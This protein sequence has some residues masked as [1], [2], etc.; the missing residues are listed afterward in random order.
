M[1]T[2]AGS[3]EQDVI[4]AE[5][6]VW[7]LGSG[8]RQYHP[9]RKWRRG[10]MGG[11]LPPGGPRPCHRPERTSSPAD[12]RLCEI[13]SRGPHPRFAGERTRRITVRRHNQIR[14]GVQQCNAAAMACW[15]CIAALGRHERQSL[16]PP[17]YS[18]RH[19]P[20]V[21]VNAGMPKCLESEST[22]VARQTT[23]RGSAPALATRLLARCSDD[24]I[25]P[26]VAARSQ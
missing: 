13:P 16:V 1:G 20:A 12:S 23:D 11:Q 18:Q 8:A 24:A 4:H 17:A 2:G 14:V 26:G 5:G 22:P 25:R 19:G 9:R 15:E 6:V 7:I 10:T 3:R 21:V